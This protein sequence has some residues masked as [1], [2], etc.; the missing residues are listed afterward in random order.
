L[1]KPGISPQV[2]QIVLTAYPVGFLVGCL[3]TRPAVAQYGH[4]RTFVVV[5]VLALLA[6]LGFVFTDFLPSWI[7]F[8][9]LGGM[10]MASLF[11][12]CESWINLYAEHHN[13]GA[14]FSIYMLTTAIAVL[15]G[16]VLVALAG[17]QSPHLFL[18]AAATVLLALVSKFVGGRWPA[19]PAAEPEHASSARP[20]KRLGPLALF[21]LAPVTVVAIFQGGITNMNI[22]VLTPIYGTQI[23]LSA[24][25]TV[26]LV[27]TI[28]IA[29]MLAQTPV[30]WLSDRFERRII[31]LVQGI[32]SV[33]LCAAI[34][35]LGNSSVPLLF[36][37]FF[38][39]GCTAL[40]VY[41]VAM[42]FG[43]SQLHSRHMVG[44]SGTLLLL[45]S[46]GNVATP[47]I[48]AGLMEHM[49]APAMFLLLGGG[50]VLVAIA[51][52]YN[53]LRRPVTMATLQAVEEQV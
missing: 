32:L 28:S 40:T 33:T 9:L 16:Q 36:V 4:E 49:G 31:L 23:G 41:P 21:R 46:I 27:T 34:A 10:A 18:V 26:G 11:V 48:S 50:A 22:F 37:L 35:W 12:V 42:A 29:G 44:A 5:L 20:V 51:A 30:G 45:Y 2:V 1:G 7:C 25:T 47:G 53:L 39:Y 13:R 38:I 6:A 8:R 52:C 3:V 17:P 24:A 14:L 15:L 43:A 19:L